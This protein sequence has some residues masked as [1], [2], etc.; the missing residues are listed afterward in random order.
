MMHADLVATI[1][2]V[3]T[4]VSFLPQV[5]RVHRTRH[6]KDLSLPMYVIFSFG[7]LLW[8]YY[9]YLSDSWPIIL[10][11]SITFVFSAYILAMK[12]RFR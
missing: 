3:C 7:V 9:G 8:A 5:M 12:I 1:A 4:T 6:T 11:N 2:A 10:A